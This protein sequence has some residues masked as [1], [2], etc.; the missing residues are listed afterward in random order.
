[1]IE[2]LSGQVK[3]HSRH[4]GDGYFRG[5]QVTI[6]EA[7]SS[8]IE[9]VV[10]SRPVH[11]VL[12]SREG[13]ALIASCSCEDANELARPCPHMWAV[14][15]AAREDGRFPGAAGPRIDRLEVAIDPLWDDPFEEA[16]PV[17]FD[18]F[19][20][21]GRIRGREARS[22]LR[23]RTTSSRSKNTGRKNTDNGMLPWGR[24][25]ASLRLGQT[26]FQTTHATAVAR[27]DELIYL[28]DLPTTLEV[29]QVAMQVLKRQRLVSGA[30]G[31]PKGIR[32]P[33]SEIPHLPDAEDRR[34]MALLCGAEAPIGYTYYARYG[35]Y[36]Q[37][38]TQCHLS[39]HQAATLLPMACATGRCLIRTM[40]EEPD[41][42]PLAWDDG[43][44]FELALDLSRAGPTRP[45]LLT[46]WL[47]RGGEKLA[48]ES[49][50][51]LF[52][53]GLV[54]HENRVARLN[55]HGAFEWVPLLRHWPRIT[56]TPRELDRFLTDLYRLPRRPRLIL[57][58]DVHLEQVRVT[59]NPRL[60]VAAPR[61]SRRAHAW[62]QAA[63]S[64]DYEGQVA[65]ASDART[66]L[67]EP[68]HRRILARDH[69]AEEAA[70]GRLRQLGLRRHPDSR[71]VTG[72][73]TLPPRRLPQTVAALLREGWQVE[74]D[75]KLYRRSS[76]FRLAGDLGRRLVR[77][78]RR[79]RIRRSVGH[80][81]RAPGRRRT[82]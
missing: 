2:R 73:F 55:D 35:Y 54:F 60:R 22:T 8:S 37:A 72:I 40:A 31:K 32:I 34:I 49:A 47:M 38:P 59:P 66:E 23:G 45:Y 62:L 69:E 77:A 26:E 28:V 42:P 11:E 56:V 10:G 58:D 33:K 53:G 82:R 79:C 7:D 65:E 78:S 80:S 20:G 19:E 43:P 4:T 63:L 44:P 13:R 36:D 48:L 70:A 46:G 68:K 24:A 51:L 74:A 16:E 15:L 41:P 27:G 81:A 3:Q 64:F 25:I 50:A 57:P 6:L 39:L 76:G 1:M 30:W 14:L 12:L 29:Q 61:S 18:P 21:L 5:G 67:Y 9:A 71:N 17:A 75:G 52:E